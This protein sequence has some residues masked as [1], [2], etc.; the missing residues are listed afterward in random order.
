MFARLINYIKSIFIKH[1]CTHNDADVV[2][3]M[4]VKPKYINTASF[5]KGKHVLRYNV[6][7][8]CYCIKC[9]TNLYKVK[10]DTNITKSRINIK[11][12][13]QFN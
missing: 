13:Y 2:Y 1:T 8:N 11:Y 4:I 7:E 3:E 9:N 6:W 10:V 5:G 12:N